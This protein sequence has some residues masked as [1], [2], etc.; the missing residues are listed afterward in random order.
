MYRNSFVWQEQDK[1]NFSPLKKDLFNTSFIQADSVEPTDT[2]TKVKTNMN[3]TNTDNF[4]IPNVC[5]YDYL[6][7]Y[8]VVQIIELQI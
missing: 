8:N 2:H 5:I 7:S 3:F 4:E 1:N 6:Q